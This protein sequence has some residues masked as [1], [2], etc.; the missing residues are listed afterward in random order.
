ML[1]AKRIIVGHTVQETG[2]TSYCDGRVWC[3]D[4]GLAKHY[5]GELQVLEIQGDQVRVLTSKDMPK[6]SH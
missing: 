3:I 2:I 4:V 1:G 6:N 5:G